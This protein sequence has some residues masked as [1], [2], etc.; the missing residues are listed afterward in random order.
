[1]LNRGFGFKASMELH[2][3][4]YVPDPKQAAENLSKTFGIPF[5]GVIDGLAG[6]DQPTVYPTDKKLRF[7]TGGVATLKIGTPFEMIYPLFIEGVSLPASPRAFSDVRLRTALELY[8]AY[9]Y[10]QSANARLL[11][12]VIALETLT[13]S[14]PKAQI[15]LDLLT[16][17]QRDISRLKVQFQAASAEHQALDSLERELVFRRD[18][19]L[20][21]QIR[22]LV[23]DTL[24]KAD[25]ANAVGLAKEAVKVYDK[26][27]TLVHE[28]SLPD[29]EL[30]WAVSEAKGI[31]EAVLKA[32]FQEGGR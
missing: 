4:T 29:K 6:G 31:V 3:V 7:V 26:R 16:G 28:G 14:S 1:M 30:Q 32:K 24:E 23:R 2:T 8:G 17:W 11:T 15:A 9:Y 13:E 12:L 27:S 25:V 18:K 5:T 20:R 19:S 10:E 21:S 22:E